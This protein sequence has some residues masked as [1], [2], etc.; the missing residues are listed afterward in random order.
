MKT[1]CER[2]GMS[3]RLILKNTADAVHSDEGVVQVR[4]AGV[5]DVVGQGWLGAACAQPRDE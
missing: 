4:Q 5:S 2:R 3:C 1:V